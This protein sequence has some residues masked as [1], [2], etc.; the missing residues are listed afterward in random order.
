MEIALIAYPPY[1]FNPTKDPGILLRDNRRF[2]MRDIGKLE[3]RIENLEE[4]TSLSLLEMKAAT[5]EV[6]DANGLNRFKSGFI[7][8]D[9]K[10]KSLADA[11]YSR[12][13]INSEQQM[14]ISPVEFWSLNAELA[15][16]PS[17]DVE[18]DDLDANLPL[19]DQNIQKTGDLLTLAYEEVDWLDQ[20]HATNV[21]NVNPFNV[22]VYSGGVQ[23][24]PP[25]DN[26]TRTIYINHKRTESTGAKWIQEAKVST[27]TDRDIKVQRYK[28]GRGRSE[29]KVR[30]FIVE[31][32][33][34]VT[35]YKPKLVGPSREFD[36]VENVKITSTVDPFMR[37]REVYFLANGLKP[38][39]KHYHFLDSQQPDIIPKIVEIAMQSGTFKSTEKVDIFKGGK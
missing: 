2:T 5:L 39:T 11:Q 15:W 18:N 33:T 24:T 8:S 38:N 37:S 25:S 14:G 22:I 27:N 20:P 36:Y 9:F 7:V 28:V 23:L 1:L 13:D 30:R 29:K 12:I 4:T 16:D 32:T 26:W 19:L 21:E 3:D 34:K 31:T 35:T 17:I 6:T 10:D